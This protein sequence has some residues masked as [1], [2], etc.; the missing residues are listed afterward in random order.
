MTI[1]NDTTGET[2]TTVA[3][4]RDGVS[5]SAFCD[6]LF[7]G[8]CDTRQAGT[9]CAVFDAV[10]GDRIQVQVED[11]LHNTVTVD[12]GNMRDERTGA[13]AIPPAG[14]VVTFPA[15]PRYQALIPDGAF[16]AATIVQI[17]PIKASPT[18]EE[19]AQGVRDVN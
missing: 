18:A 10:V 17:A 1:L 4:D 16:E 7:P 2:F 8:R 6:S 14:G 13:T 15:D 19:L 12:A 9:F 11:V 3:T 5:G